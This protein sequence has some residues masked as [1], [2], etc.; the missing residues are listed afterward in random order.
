MKPEDLERRAEIA[1]R[2]KAARWLAGGIRPTDTGKVG[3]EVVALSPEALARRAPL[4]ENG[5]SASL[6]GSIERME[7]HTQPMELRTIASALDLP[8]AWFSAAAAHNGD[9]DLSEEE[10]RQAAELL[11][12]QL[13]AAARALR[14]ARGQGPPDTDAPGRPDEGAGGGP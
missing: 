7:R 4:A 5:I 9:G 3:Q 12:P 2:L 13:V 10:L 8:G 6:I 1:R 14:R 11:A